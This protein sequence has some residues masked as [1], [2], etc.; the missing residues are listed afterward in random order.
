[1]RSEKRQRVG[2]PLMAAFPEGRVAVSVR[3]APSRAKV[4]SGRASWCPG[5][6]EVGAGLSTWPVHP[7]VPAWASLLSPENAG[8]APCARTHTHTCT[9]TRAHT[10][11]LTRVHTCTH[12]HMCACARN[13]LQKLRE[14]SMLPFSF[15]S[16]AIGLRKTRVAHVPKSG[17]VVVS[18]CH[19]SGVW[20]E[21][22]VG[23]PRR[24]SLR[25]SRGGLQEP[26]L[27]P[28]LG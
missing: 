16:A 22:G 10:C 14:Q 28:R 1:M 13:F 5:D 2:A 3:T 15:R 27:C 18:R 17:L 21:S 24:V 9:H 25:G 4:P 20:E 12:T 26:A 8:H 19:T 6:T 11:A 7:S 23:A